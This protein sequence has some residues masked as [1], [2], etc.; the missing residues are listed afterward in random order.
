MTPL[1]ES[2]T[3]AKPCTCK[4]H[5]IQK[6]QTLMSPAGFELTVP[7]S[8]WQQTY[9]LDSAIA[10]ID[11]FNLIMKESFLLDEGWPKQPRGVPHNS[12]TTL[13]RATL[14]YT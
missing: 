2:F 1:D 4:P 11:C 8:K 7:T 5:N 3:F 13:L 6:R 12:V 14:L 9:T 10:G